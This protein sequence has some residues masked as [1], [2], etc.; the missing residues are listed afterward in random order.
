MVEKIKPADS[1]L[2]PIQQIKINVTNIHKFLI[3]QN[4]KREEEKE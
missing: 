3:A 2:P 4:K 1:K